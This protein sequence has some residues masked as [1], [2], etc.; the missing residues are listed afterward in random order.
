MA[1]VDASNEPAVIR[2]FPVEQLSEDVKTRFEQL[3][4]AKDSWTLDEITPY[5][6][7]MC[8]GKLTVSVLVMKNARGFNKGGVKHY[9]SKYIKS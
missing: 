5:V 9:T 1:F 4:S 7:P 6:E 8:I 2:Y 3:F